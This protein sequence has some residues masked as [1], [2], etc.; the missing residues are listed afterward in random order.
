MSTTRWEIDEHLNTPRELEKT[1]NID[2]ASAPS[3]SRVRGWFGAKGI[4]AVLVLALVV[5]VTLVQLLYH[6]STSYPDTVR[7]AG[8]VAYWRLNDQSGLVAASALP[9]HA[10]ARYFGVVTLGTAG[11]ITNAAD[12]AAF[13]NGASSGVQAAT[14]I[15]FG[16][17]SPFSLTVWVKPSPQ[18]D[19]LGRIISEE[20]SRGSGY[21]LSYGP[22]A[23]EFTRQ[24][25]RARRDRQQLSV[26]DPVST[27]SFTFVAVTFDGRTMRL[28]I[29]ASL[30]ADVSG[31]VVTLPSGS[32]PA[33]RIGML[34][35]ASRRPFRGALGEV[36][37][38][39]R[40]LSAG[41]VQR[42]WHASGN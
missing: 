17:D 26:T 20:N 18:L 2:D 11:P 34:A 23:W 27:S 39:A 42:L 33:L 36:A 5:A 10:S 3:R 41:D 15:P 12:T 30:I 24:G 19:S 40:A 31:P 21:S 28:Y 29:D 4:V 1:P 32:Y 9:A 25:A 13:F 37:V 6:A 35:I 7:N 16:G 22:S 8:A 38:F 14:S